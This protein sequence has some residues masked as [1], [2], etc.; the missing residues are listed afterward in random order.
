MIEDD[1]YRSWSS[2]RSQQPHDY[3]IR[4]CVAF[5][6]G[7]CYVEAT[8]VELTTADIAMI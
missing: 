1:G 3:V 6:D 2:L 7:L 4:G 8:H 5:A